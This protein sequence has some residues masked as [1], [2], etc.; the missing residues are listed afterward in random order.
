[1]SKF[2][3]IGVVAALISLSLAGTAP[4]ATAI[5][6]TNGLVIHLDA[7]NSSS[8]N[9]SG[10]A[11]T[12]LSGKGNNA[13]LVNGP[14]YSAYY[15]KYISFDGTNDYA[16]IGSL[17]TNFS[18]GFSASFYANFGSAQ[19]YERIIDFGN[20]A[21]SHNILIARE[22]T[23]TDM[24]LSLNSASASLGF[25]RASGI[26]TNDIWANYSVVLNGADCYFYRNGIYF[27]G[28]T[29]YNAAGTSIVAQTALPTN[30]TRTSNFIGESN[31]P[32]DDYFAGGIG[33][34]AIYNRGITSTE[35]WQNYKA[36]ANFCST[37]L[38][39]SGSTQYVRVPLAD[40]CLWQIPS[41]VSTLDYFIIGGG[42][43]GGGANAG[44]LGGG[45]GGGGGAVLSATSYSVTG[46]TSLTLN[47]GG[48]GYAGGVNADGGGGGTTS[49]RTSTGTVVAALGGYGGQ[50]SPGVSNQD[51]LSGDGGNS[52]GGNAGGANVWDGGGGGAG[53]GGAGTA[54]SDIGGQGGNGGAGGAGVQNS[55]ITNVAT[56]FG[57]GGGGG[58]TP[59]NNVIAASQTDGFGA[60][61]GSSVGGN[62]GVVSSTKGV[63]TN[64]TPN[65]GSGGGG[66]GWNYN[67]TNTNKQGGSGSHGA[68]YFKFTKSPPT[69]SSISVTSSSG[70]DSTYTYGETITVTVFWAEA[71]T[72]TGSP[73]IPLQGL[74][75]KYLT[76][77]SGSDSSQLLFTYVVALNDL[78]VDGFSISL[79]SLALNG[80]TLTDSLGLSAGI[81]H[82]AI[83]A[84]SSLA[85]DGRLDGTVNSIS[86]SGTAYY[87]SAVTITANVSIVGKV[88]FKANGARITGCLKSTASGTTPNIT[89]TCSWKPSK[90]GDNKITATISPT[91]GAYS[92]GSAS[93]QVF[94]T[95][96]VGTR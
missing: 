45:G 42:G 27:S 20:G 74:S 70:A 41:G 86:F 69:L 89:A 19:S 38:T 73:R 33:E 66:G 95:K 71:I 24:V 8:Y 58:G 62:G 32:N 84:S 47:V 61:G 57:A 44:S 49:F 48:G 93:T 43:G 63:A 25:C 12:D 39:T 17:T 55:S 59:S 54:G 80:G 30:V 28:V 36:Q 92:S 96:R 60:L 88:M 6:S 67:Y 34:V 31:W 4:A 90:R 14:A 18:A 15:G 56:F 9:G 87:R 10:T 68:I 65:T 75:G 85:I 94:V 2:L 22:G 82:S 91:N 26:I 40:Q 11:W 52:G 77:S 76:Y 35:V 21:N 83:S 53:A 13:T 46:G 72:V 16:T 50:G 81:T 78:D 3:R 1:M 5:V 29:R 23:S 7:G 64:A 37:D 51:N 79:N